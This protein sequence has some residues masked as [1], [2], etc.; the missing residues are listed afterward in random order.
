MKFLTEKFRD[1]K[2][3]EELF[4]DAGKSKDKGIMPC[5]MPGRDTDR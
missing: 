3:Y 4:S 2:A 1:E 5:P